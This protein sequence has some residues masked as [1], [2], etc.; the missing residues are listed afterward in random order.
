MTEFE[1]F[2]NFAFL[3]YGL[4][5]IKALSSCPCNFYSHELGAVNFLIRRYDL[6]LSDME[7]C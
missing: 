2:C 1:L 5:L 6:A 7:L 3:T 4:Y